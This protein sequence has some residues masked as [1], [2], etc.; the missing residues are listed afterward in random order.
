VLAMTCFVLSGFASAD[1]SRATLT[2]VHQK[3]HKHKAHKAAKHKTPR[4][5]HHTI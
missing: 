1:V 3:I 2:T 4:R 5:S